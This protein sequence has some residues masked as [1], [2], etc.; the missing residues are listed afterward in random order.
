MNNTYP[1]IIDSSQFP[2]W[3]CII[4]LSEESQTDDILSQE[5]AL[6]TICELKLSDDQKEVLTQQILIRETLPLTNLDAKKYLEEVV[7]GMEP[8]VYLVLD[9]DAS[10]GYFSFEADLRSECFYSKEEGVEMATRFFQGQMITEDQYMDL[11][12]Q[13]EDSD[14]P[15]DGAF[16]MTEEERENLWEQIKNIIQPQIIQH[17]TSG[18][19]TN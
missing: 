2:E 3:G 15:E 9:N 18:F 14:L 8:V 19:Y 17:D 1:H 10:V 7:I 13:I 4:V 16:M 11:V 12:G 6:K 5:E